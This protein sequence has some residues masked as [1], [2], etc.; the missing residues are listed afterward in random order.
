GGEVLRGGE[1]VAGGVVHQP[2]HKPDLGGHRLHRREVAHVAGEGAG[3]A[4]GGPDLGDHLV[5]LLLAPAQQHA[6]GAQPRAAPRHL[7]AESGSTAR[8]H[9]NLVFQESSLEHARHNADPER[10]DQARRRDRE[11]AADM[12]SA[13]LLG[14]LVAAAP[15]GK[16]V[17][18][19]VIDQLRYADLL[20]LAP[21]LGHKG[22]AG[23]GRP[24]PMRYETAVAET[25]PGHAVLST[26]A[27]ADVN[28]IVG[29]SFWQTNRYQEAVED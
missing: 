24:A 10:I 12:I 13:L 15:Q 1:E 3:L 6:A 17:V 11:G 28:G 9:E 19:V 29:N 2:V 23:L 16:L 14:A 21:E 18:L 7:R 20:W 26:G 25:A 8:D 22:F 4:A 5:E 27:Y